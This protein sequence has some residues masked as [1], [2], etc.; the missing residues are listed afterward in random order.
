MA[1]PA[2][3]GAPSPPPCRFI[4]DAD[5]FQQACE[6]RFNSSDACHP[7]APAQAIPIG[8]DAPP[9]QTF[10]LK[11][12]VN[13]ERIDENEVLMCASEFALRSVGFGP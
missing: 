2:V 1:T 3:V 4:E 6:D 12:E 7:S 10:T 9:K 5:V 8:S 13:E 11:L